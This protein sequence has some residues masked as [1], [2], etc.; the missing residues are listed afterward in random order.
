MPIIWTYPLDIHILF[1]AHPIQLY[2]A[3][4][5]A[6]TMLKSTHIHWPTLKELK[7]FLTLLSYFNYGQTLPWILDMT[8]LT[9]FS[10]PD[11]RVRKMPVIGGEKKQSCFNICH[12]LGNIISYFQ[13]YLLYVFKRCT[14]KNPSKKVRYKVKNKNLRPNNHS[15]FS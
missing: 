10:C 11:N 5:W 15:N 3:T 7:S 8:D 12:K 1:N 4:L 9:I 6:K 13:N 2:M 14:L